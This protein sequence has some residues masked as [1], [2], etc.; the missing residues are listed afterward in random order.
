MPS[1]V[2]SA[3]AETAIRSGRRGAST[4]TGELL[5]NQA[6]AIEEILLSLFAGVV[7]VE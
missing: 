4:A 3:T 7:G 1:I 5:L 2:P 6:N